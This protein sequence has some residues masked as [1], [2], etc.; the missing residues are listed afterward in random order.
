MRNL[1]TKIALGLA[2]VFT[3]LTGAM[4]AGD[5]VDLRQQN[6]SFNGVF[7]KYDR[8]SA[9]R[10]FQVYREVCSAC[11]GLKYVAFRNL[12]EIG[13]PENMA[14]AIAA[15]Y[16][17][18]DGP[19]DFGDMFERPGKLSDYLPSPFANENA[20]R[21]SNGGALPP[22]LSLI[23]KARPHGPDYLYSILTGY[24]D[25]PAGFELASGMSYNTYFKGQAI[26][27]PVPLFDEQV[28]YMDGTQ[29][30]VEQMS[31]DLVMFLQWTAEPKLE[32]RHE[33]G[34]KVM[35]FLILLTGLTY[36]VNKRVWAPIKDKKD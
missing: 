32:E 20:A 25:A 5:S 18:E 21:A 27:M 33:A 3:S 36:L 30:S 28:E 35:T 6:W 15:E 11:H 23:T 34:F 16:T 1:F 24:K 13:F 22:D 17:V 7:G 26:A 10:G 29:A 12:T 31:Q 2:F 8:A 14:K 4:A 19:D 9:Q